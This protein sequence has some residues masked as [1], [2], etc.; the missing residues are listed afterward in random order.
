MKKLVWILLSLLIV[1]L[2]CASCDPGTDTSTPAESKP[3]D[4][5]SST[6]SEAEMFSGLRD[7]DGENSEFWFLVGGM[8]YGDRYQSREIGAEELNNELINDA[9]YNRNALVEDKF[10]IDIVCYATTSAEKIDTILSTEISTQMYTYDVVMPIMNNMVSGAADGYFYD[11]YGDDIKS[12]L[13]LTKEWWDQRANNDLSIGGKLYFTTGY[14]SIL[15]NEC[16]QAMVFNKT[17]LSNAELESPYNLVKDGK[18]TYDK[19]NELAAS[20][21]RDA[22]GVNGMSSK[23][24]YGCWFNNGSGQAMF[25]GSGNR[26]I[27]KDTNDYPVI[28]VKDGN[29]ADVVDKIAALIGGNSNAIIIENITDYAPAS[30][31]YYFATEAVAT[32]RALFR[33]MCLVDL[34]ELSEYE[35]DYGILPIPKYSEDQDDYYCLVSTILVPGIAIPTTN[36]NPANAALILS[37]MG[38]ASVNTL[39]TAYYDTMLKQ[40]KVIDTESGDML[41]I[42]FNN[43]VYD[44]GVVFGWGNIAQTMALGNSVTTS[45][46]SNFTS[47]FQSIESSVQTA[48]DKTI[49]S[50]ENQ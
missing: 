12:D 10:N 37:A 33:T 20:V 14:M 11:L 9:V 34:Y 22:D 17:V 5:T 26:F 49:E 48:M 38:E 50:F 31:V 45:G 3:T 44:L 2:V 39:N 42:I 28:A 35:C 16:T 21:T 19:V 15:D 29:A 1:S 40:R 27:S 24:T 25:I 32:G 23:D 4:S 47:Y 6:T 18:W 43:R 30:D 8:E 7:W 36:Q 46:T 41:D 13:D